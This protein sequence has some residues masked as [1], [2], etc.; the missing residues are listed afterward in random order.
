MTIRPLINNPPQPADAPVPA[1]LPDVAGLAQLANAF[2]ASL[3]G[4][5]PA[6]PGAPPGELAPAVSTAQVREAP[7]V[8]GADG[9]DLGSPEA[10]AA[11][12]PSVFPS[13]GGLA[14]SAGGTPSSPYY[15]LGEGS[16]YAGEP[17]RFAEIPVEPGS[18]AVPGGD[19][20]GEILRSI[21]AE[22]RSA[23]AAAPGPGGGQFYFLDR[24]APGLEKA[25]DPA[26]QPQ[27]RSGFDVQAIRRDFPILAE[28]VNGK[29]LVWFD[30]AATTQKPKA[31]IDRL[32]YFYE[33]ENSNIHRAAHELAARATD[34]Y[35]GARNKA[36]RFLGAKSAEEIVFV[37]GAT[38]GI[39][40][41]ANTFGRQFIGAGDE[42]IVSHLEHHANIVPWQQLANVVGAKLKVIPV[43]DSGQILLEEY[44]RL[45]GPRTKLV[46][47]T[48]VS[49]ALGT[50]TPVAEVIALAH[51]AGAR[52]LVDGAQSV[53]HLK[54]DVQ[55][56]DADFFVF[57][58]HK[59]FGP[60]GIGVVY[61]KKELLD[62]LPPWQ[63]GGN[64]IADVTFE[65][66]L[67]QGAPA[68]FEA[69][70]GNIAD[71]VGL[72]A[73]LDYVERIGLERIARYEH[74]LLEYATR[75]LSAIPGLRLIGTAADKASVLSFVLQGYRTEEVGA[76]LNREGI[77]VRSGHHCAQPILRR[78]GLET[79]VRPSL[80]FYNTF[81]EID[82]LVS[83]VQ[84]LATRR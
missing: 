29:P 45:L 71:A 11:A 2:F 65:K 77:A 44:A 16:A 52:V 76:A 27:V 84:R 56:L 68:R 23:P 64:M 66:T 75:G 58:G 54:V 47:I 8:G 35:E 15:F 49:N 6:R 14:P 73:A 33:H 81:E 69:G 10:Y 79:T 7:P 51:A 60:T 32:T 38:E 83:T 41:L 82:L 70:T 20:L 21:L 24:V 63:G 13:A 25:P 53:S 37:R 19:A 72:G 9:L 55:A 61:G 4:G 17:E 78:F 50:V 48:Q 18:L 12:L 28:R 5:A 42:I 46:S 40:L 22:E 62:E 36:A 34:A 74:E 59:I 80:A 3:P 39:N 1:G 43:D 57:S 30:N 31:V 67:Y 26:G